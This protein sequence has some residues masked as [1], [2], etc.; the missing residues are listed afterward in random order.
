MP[1]ITTLLL[2]IGIALEEEGGTRATGD[3]VG[4]E[5]IEVVTAAR[6]SFVDAAARSSWTPR[7][8]TL[9]PVVG[10]WGMGG[11]TMPPA[12]TTFAGQPPQEVERR[13]GQMSM[14]VVKMVAAT[15]VTMAAVVSV[16]M[17]AGS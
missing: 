6:D 4:T 13:G 7:P 2:S 17:R 15:S 1:L 14:A 9:P 8:S 10:G 3:V 12:T 5:T 16:T 11:S